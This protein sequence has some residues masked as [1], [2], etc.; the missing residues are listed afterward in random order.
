[1]DREG[2]GFGDEILLGPSTGIEG[3]DLF[4]AVVRNGLAM[5]VVSHRNPQIVLVFGYPPRPHL[6][7][8]ELETFL[9]HTDELLAVELLELSDGVFIDGVNKEQNF[10]ALLLENL[11]EG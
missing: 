3:V 2:V 5:V 6:S 1:M 8:S 10:E 4:E 9:R 7:P 11:K